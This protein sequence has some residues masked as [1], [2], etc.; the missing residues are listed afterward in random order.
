MRYGY[1]LLFG[2]TV[3]ETS[4]RLPVSPFYLL[5]GELLPCLLLLMGL[6]LLVVPVESHHVPWC[7]LLFGVGLQQAE[8][9]HACLFPLLPALLL[10]HL[11][12]PFGDGRKLSRGAPA[13]VV[14]PH[15][16]APQRECKQLLYVAR[17]PF[18]GFGLVFFCSPVVS[19]AM[20]A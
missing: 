12:P 3:T 6:L 11:H 18:T 14:Q 8:A 20:T 15:A 5:G 19:G 10:S 16:D 9:G 13:E 17:Q 7:E 4:E 2:L 1:M